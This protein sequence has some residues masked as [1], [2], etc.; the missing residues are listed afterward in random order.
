MGGL[1]YILCREYEKNEAQSRYESLSETL[2]GSYQVE[3]C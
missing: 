2:T 1:V 3:I